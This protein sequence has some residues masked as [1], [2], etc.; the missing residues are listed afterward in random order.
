MKE[1][2]YYWDS[3]VFV[4]FFNDEQE[5][6]R[7]DMVEQ[8]LD[9]AEAGRISIV[10]S[11]FALV[12]VSKLQGHKPLSA[13][14]ER[15]IVDFFEY[16]FIHLVDATR[17]ICEDARRLIW[18][19]PSLFPKDA[20]HLAS[21]LAYAQREHLDGLFSYD[22]DFLKLNG[23]I[24]TKFPVTQPFM[25]QMKLSLSDEAKMDKPSRKFRLRD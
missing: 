3:S 4:A 16:P 17:D 21:A 8:L 23:V 18:S 10:T 20:V 2:M 5:K 22:D 6:Q 9:E 19:H 12:E 7:A 24:T 14:D 11:S 25:K 15:K 13:S 1:L